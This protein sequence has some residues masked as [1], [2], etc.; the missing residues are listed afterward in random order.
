MRERGSNEIE[1]CA[2]RAT[3]VEFTHEL[4]ED[5]ISGGA[6]NTYCVANILSYTSIP[7]Y[8]FKQLLTCS[9]RTPLPMICPEAG[10]S[11]SP[12]Y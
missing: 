4:M 12:I 10:E 6:S 11:H 7:I 3:L 5:E 1:R 8:V 2:V 9:S